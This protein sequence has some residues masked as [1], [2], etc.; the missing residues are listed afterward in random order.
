MLFPPCC[1]CA[2]EDVACPILARRKTDMNSLEGAFRSLFEINMGMRPY[3]SAEAGE[4]E[5]V[6]VFSDTIR[7][8][9]TLADIDRDRRLCLNATARAA[10]EFAGSC[11]GNACFVEFPATSASGVEPPE[12]L[13]RATFGEA[14]VDELVRAGLLEKLLAKQATDDDLS[15][16]RRIVLDLRQDAADVIIAMSNNSTSHTRY[17]ALANDTGARFASLPHFDPDMFHGSM[18]VDWQALAARTARLAQAVNRAD[19]LLVRTP[20]GTDMRISKRGRNAEGDDG[21][22]IAPGS[23]GNLPAGEVYL[24]PLEGESS[25]V[26]VIEWGPTRKL[27]QPLCCTVERGVVIAM[28][29]DEQQRGMLEARF[30][31]NATCRNIAELG[32][33]TNDRA[34][35]PDNVLEAEKILGTIHIAL[36]DNTGFGGTVSAP[37]HED[38]VF[39]R[40][41]LTAVMADGSEMVIIDDGNLLV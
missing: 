37:F 9:E 15:R 27:E 7:D 38:Y 26:M 8:D 29:G 40:P 36:G 32:I 31:E 11:W 13:W 28:E 21:L 2:I 24:A 16:A 20:N 1:F 34:S 10:A 6:L 14:A 35:R 19:W 18:T 22:L 3:C 33:G 12:T 5:R 30:A 25:G 4:W 23:F 39:Y 41:T 17:R